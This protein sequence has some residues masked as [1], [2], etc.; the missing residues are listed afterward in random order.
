MFML[1]HH[2]PCSHTLWEASDLAHDVCSP[3]SRK[4]GHHK[5]YQAYRGFI[6]LVFPPRKILELQHWH[7]FAINDFE[8]KAGKNR[9]F[10]KERFTEVVREGFICKRLWLLEPTGST[11]VS[12]Y[13]PNLKIWNTY[14]KNCLTY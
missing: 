10:H 11:L 7:Q 12:I 4:S 9:E 2:S 1:L 5:I 6:L 8:I 3:I 14:L 13:P